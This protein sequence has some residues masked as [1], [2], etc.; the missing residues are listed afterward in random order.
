MNDIGMGY[1][2]N[3]GLEIVD[4]AKD[5]EKEGRY[6]QAAK[7]YQKAREFF[8][9][10]RRN[11]LYA[12]CIVAHAVN[13]IKFS[14]AVRDIEEF[15][16]NPFNRYIKKI[17]G[18]KD[19]MYLEINKVDKYD[20]SIAAYREL[21]KV[22]QESHMVDKEN[23]MYYKKT[24]LYH[25]HRLEMARQKDRNLKERASDFLSSILNFFLNKFC[26]HGEKPWRAMAWI[27]FYI[28]FF[29]V[30]FKCFDLIAFKDPGK[31][32]CCLQSLYFS[33]V[34]FTTL[35]YGDIVPRD[36]TGQ[37]FVVIEVIVGFLMLGLFLATI[38]RKM[39][40]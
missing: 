33:V 29:S 4:R 24:S 37:V 34:T 3:E 2:V 28:I 36:P 12:Q 8:K 5:H 13:M 10:S 40:K 23:E 14:M 39:T 32:V 1:N 7:E 18:I 11:K 9:K 27:L 26:G 21:E 31:T 16:T 30:L 15:S 22:F 17:D 19:N 35:G 25:K 6:D 20:I 38:I